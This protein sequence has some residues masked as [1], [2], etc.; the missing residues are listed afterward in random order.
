MPSRCG[1]IA[2]LHAIANACAPALAARSPVGAFALA[3]AGA[4]PDARGRALL[5]CDALKSASDAAAGSAVAQT[6]C[7]DRHGP[8][9]DHH[10]VAFVRSPAGRLV[11]LDGT[12]P[13]PV[14]HGPTSAPTLLRDAAAAVRRE[15][16]DV[17]P[18]SIEFSLMA[19]VADGGEG[20]GAGDA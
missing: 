7:P 3:H 16:M 10:F 12:K 18:D 20:G 2:A 6:A 14:D 11:E 4:S 9:L 17:E 19:L 13:A 8:D 15:F 1:T 5:A